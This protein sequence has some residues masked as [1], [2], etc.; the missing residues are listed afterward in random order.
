[1]SGVPAA[2]QTYGRKQFGG[3][4]RVE[5]FDSRLLAVSSKLAAQ[6]IRTAHAVPHEVV[7]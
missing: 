6:E 4:I 1:M 5:R 3:K 2:D 7:K